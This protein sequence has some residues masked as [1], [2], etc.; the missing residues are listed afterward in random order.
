MRASPVRPAPQL[1]IPIDFDVDFTEKL[2]ML[3]D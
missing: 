2:V 1:H 3:L